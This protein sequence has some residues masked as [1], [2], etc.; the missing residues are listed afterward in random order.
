VDDLERFA[1][2]DYCYLTTTGRVTGEPREIEIWFGLAGSTLYLLSG[3]GV[4]DGR[5]ASQWVRNILKQPAVSVRIAGETFGGR[6]R[7]VSQGTDEDALARR[8]LLAK[9][10]PGYSGSLD[11]WGRTALPVAIEL[12]AAK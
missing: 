4:R 6:G 12:E 10:Q 3:A 2:E 1:G 8:M 11:E 5:P 7:V 9:Y